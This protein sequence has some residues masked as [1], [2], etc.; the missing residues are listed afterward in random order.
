[1]ILYVR[2]A[3][4][5]VHWDGKKL[6]LTG[7]EQSESKYFDV[8][9]NYEWA[10]SAPCTHLPE[11]SGIR[12][13]GIALWPNHFGIIFQEPFLD[14][15]LHPSWPNGSGPWNQHMKNRWQLQYL[16]TSRNPGVIFYSLSSHQIQTLARKNL[17]LAHIGLNLHRFAS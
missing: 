9:T 2:I 3:I 12:L 14:Q 1:M 13:A 6:N 11:N 17:Q 4:D 8:G 15:V 7:Q 10:P 5:K 16:G